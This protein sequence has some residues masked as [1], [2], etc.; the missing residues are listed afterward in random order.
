MN[1]DT[2]T[3]FAYLVGIRVCFLPGL[4]LPNTS[5]SCYLGLR[6][7]KEGLPPDTSR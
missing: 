2:D 7:Q 4:Y 3:Q 1:V 5:R 6:H